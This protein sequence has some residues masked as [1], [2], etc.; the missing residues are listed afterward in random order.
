MK[1]TAPENCHVSII[2]LHDSSSGGPLASLFRS[3]DKEK[4]SIIVDLDGTAPSL[5]ILNAASE[6]N[7][8]GFTHILLQS[9]FGLTPIMWQQ[10]D[11]LRWLSPEINVVT[12]FHTPRAYPNEEERAL[13]RQ[14]SR[15]SNS[16]VSMSHYACNSLK[17]AFGIPD[18]KLNM[19]PHGVKRIYADMGDKIISGFSKKKNPEKLILLSDGLIHEHKGYLRM[20]RALPELVKV[21]PNVV[22]RIVGKQ[23]PKSASMK[24]MDSYINEARSLGVRKNIEWIDTFFTQEELLE[25]YSECDIYISLYEE[26]T[27]TSG[28]LT[29]A[30]AAGMTIVATPYRYAVELL[31]NDCGVVLPSFDINNNNS[32]SLVQTLITLLSDVNLRRLYGQQAAQRVSSWR[33]PRIS[34]AYWTLLTNSSSSE[35]SPPIIHSSPFIDSLDSSAFWSGSYLYDF[36]GNLVDFPGLSSSTKIISSSLVLENDNSPKKDPFDLIAGTVA[37]NSLNNGLLKGRFC[38]AVALKSEVNVLD[39]LYSIYADN[40]I[41]INGAIFSDGTIRTVGIRTPERYILV[42]DGF[43]IDIEENAQIGNLSSTI[44]EYHSSRITLKSAFIMIVVDNS[45]IGKGITLQISNVSRF[46]SPKGIIGDTL[47]NKYDQSKRDFKPESATSDWSEWLLDDENLFSI[48]SKGQSWSMFS[49]EA[50]VYYIPTLH[51]L[52]R[53][54]IAYQNQWI[55]ISYSHYTSIKLARDIYPLISEKNF[56]PVITLQFEG[57][58]FDYSGFATVNRALFMELFWKNT[59]IMVRLAPTD[60]NL[61]VDAG[62]KPPILD[63]VVRY[64]LWANVAASRPSSDIMSGMI[65]TFGSS[66]RSRNGIEGISG[67]STP[68]PFA[69]IDSVF[70]PRRTPSNLATSEPLLAA[71]L[72]RFFPLLATSIGRKE[73]RGVGSVD[74]APDIIFR[75]AWLSGGGPD[76]SFPRSLSTFWMQSQPWEFWGIPES[77]IP[78]LSLVDALIVP[79]KFSKDSYI[80]NG[81]KSDRI[82][83]LPHGV[84]FKKIQQIVSGF[85]EFRR[86]ENSTSEYIKSLPGCG[87][88]ITIFSGGLLARKGVDIAVKAF[89]SAFKRTDEACLVMHTVY[90]DGYYIDQIKTYQADYKAASKDLSLVHSQPSRYDIPR[91]VYLD[92]ALEWSEMIELFHIADLFLAPYRAEGFGLIILEAMAAGTA[93]AVTQAGP[94][95]EFTNSESAFYI[96]QNI[97][98]EE[99]EQSTNEQQTFYDKNEWQ[100]KATVPIAICRISPCG[101]GLNE[102]NG[103]KTKVPPR[104]ASPSISSTR[105]VLQTAYYNPYMVNEKAKRGLEIARNYT[106]TQPGTELEALIQKMVFNTNNDSDPK[107]LI[108][109]RLKATL[110]QFKNNCTDAENETAK[111]EYNLQDLASVSLKDSLSMPVDSS[112]GVENSFSIRNIFMSAMSLPSILGLWLL[113]RIF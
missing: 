40:Q 9:E 39:C 76:L 71:L 58:I 7:N 104:W 56:V 12:V 67:S 97:M 65:R 69:H 5:S 11:L 57:P 63:S 25:Y 88:F 43:P 15:L 86:K 77:W 44:I 4:V 8:A 102:I 81:I 80:A 29:A 105:K 27:P 35:L 83:V 23:H 73:E 64:L 24:L 16:V 48:Q 28:T 18:E 47:Q 101:P 21:F 49:M 75:N 42:Q 33:W 74:S 50:N 94:A 87:K 103:Y 22:F 46:S 66:G 108:P 13:L 45:M 52:P 59:K 3:Y 70:Q 37:G 111:K 41:Q 17:H 112:V 55:S 34:N 84:T 85:N 93:V 79:S 53:N 20:I 2:A 109:E 95:L 92:Y 6:I 30:M 61:E 62:A 91:I 14:V 99:M 113:R 72:L 19:I 107:A 89:I 78:N 38:S 110:C 26:I 90:G 36:V 54:S 100:S 60:P 82:I 51:D 96:S 1:E 106:W 32:H 31:S 10:A 98:T 68:T